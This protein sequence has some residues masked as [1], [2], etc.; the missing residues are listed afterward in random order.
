MPVVRG[1]RKFLEMLV[2][3]GED[4]AAQVKE[5]YRQASEHGTARFPAE[6]GSIRR[7]GICMSHPAG[8]GR[9]IAGM[10]GSSVR[11]RQPHHTPYA[12]QNTEGEDYSFSRIPSPISAFFSGNPVAKTPAAAFTLIF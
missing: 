6:P 5:E 4:E 9:C 8:E 11:L 3:H 7:T 10:P 1:C 2:R 12:F